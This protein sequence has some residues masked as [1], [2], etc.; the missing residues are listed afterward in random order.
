[1][2]KILILLTITLSLYSKPQTIVFGA[3]C[4]WGVEKHFDNLEGV[5]RATAGYA[6]GD[7]KNPTYKEVVGNRYNPKNHTEVVEVV[8]EDKNISTNSLIKSF[9]ELH[10]PT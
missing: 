10:D 6:G 3:E 1:M 9:W 8:Y 5:I 7:Y 2:K 4:F